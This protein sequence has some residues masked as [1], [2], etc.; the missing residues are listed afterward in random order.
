VTGESAIGRAW[1]QVDEP[2]KWFPLRCASASPPLSRLLHAPEAGRVDQHRDEPDGKERHS[3]DPRD[4]PETG[5]DPDEGRRLGD[6]M[7]DSDGD[8]RRST[9]TERL[10]SVDHHEGHPRI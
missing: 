4:V 5:D 10:L 1:A 8:G 9:A 2:T 3:R 6:R 7:S